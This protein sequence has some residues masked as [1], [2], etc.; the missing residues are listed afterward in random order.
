MWDAE[1][2]AYLDLYASIGFCVRD[3]R[4][5]TSQIAQ[6]AWLT[7]SAEGGSMGVAPSTERD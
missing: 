3:G 5:R 1:G 2:G 6:S 4:D 7:V